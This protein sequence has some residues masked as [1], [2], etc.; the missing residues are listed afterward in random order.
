MNHSRRDLMHKEVQPFTRSWW[1]GGVRNLFWVVLVTLLIFIYADMEF[2]DEAAMDV[3][4][5]LTTG[6]SQ[7]LVLL[8]PPDQELKF[9]ISGSQS[10]L[11]NLRK[12]L[13]TMGN[14][15]LYD[16]SH[17]HSS[18]E[19]FLPAKDLLERAAEQA[20]LQMRG[21][22]VETIAPEAVRVELDTIT[23]VPNVPV[24]L[25][26]QGAKLATPPATQSVTLRAPTSQWN[27]IR[28]SLGRG[29]VPTLKT[30]PVDLSASPV[31][32]TTVAAV[33]NPQ[34]AG[35]R[36]ETTPEELS[37]HVE[38]INPMETREIKL[39]VGIESPASWS[40]PDGVWTNYLLT[41][42]A[43]SDWLITLTVVGAKKDLR[44]EN[45]QAY[46]TLTEDDKKP[47]T[48][49]L[50]REIH[51][52]FAPNTNLRLSEPA[53]KLKFRLKKRSSLPVEP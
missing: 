3:T 10:A 4:I 34:I 42:Q 38:I 6:D 44:P 48:S 9:T 35:Q 25:V 15:I 41:R 29:V 37:F 19:Q 16:V 47:V 30:K 32:E 14:V 40:E 52:R 23:T 8:S 13:A 46:I 49:W 45:I 1:L 17:D 7:R 33:V 12:S 43:A 20:G 36:I 27:K 53:P 28:E 24:T 50:D 26:Y 11:G 5:R 39:S 51:V 18:G 31:G 21:L 22:A 2:T